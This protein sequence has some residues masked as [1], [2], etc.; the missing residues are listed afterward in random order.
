MI[1]H[2]ADGAV[3]N[4]LDDFLTGFVM[5]PHEA[6][7][8]FEVLL[9]RQL[10]ALENAL[11]AGSIH[12]KGFFHKHVHPF[13]HGVGEMS[14]PERG[15]SGED[16]Q[17]IFVQRIDGLF[18]GVESGELAFGRDFGLLGKALS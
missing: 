4:A 9:S 6:A 14:G 1:D 15:R 13:F 17:V 16:Y 8:H 18:V 10:A 11:Y 5:P 2:V 7:S 3:V 12:G